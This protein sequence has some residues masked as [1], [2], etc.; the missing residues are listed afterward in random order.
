MR[1]DVGSGHVGH[2]AYRPDTDAHKTH[3]SRSLSQDLCDA[4]GK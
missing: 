4:L 3:T 1:Y 2:G